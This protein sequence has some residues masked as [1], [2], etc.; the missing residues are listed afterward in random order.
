MFVK[1]LWRYPVKSLSGERLDTALVD[2]DGIYGDRLVH[3]R[4]TSRI[5][6]ARTRYG[7]LGLSSRLRED[8]VPLIDGLPWDDPRSRAAVRVAAGED[9]ELYDDGLVRFDILPL[10]V[11][12][13]GALEAFGRDHRRLRPNIVIGGVEGLAERAWP[14]HALRVGDV[15]IGVDSLR[16]RCVMTTFD[17]DTLEQDVG[18]LREIVDRFDGRIAL[19]CDV[20]APGTIQVGDLVELVELDAVTSRTRSLATP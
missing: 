11:A 9:V 5:V 15:V 19:N 13:D 14:G 1:E 18:V 20:L 6:T 17:P 4:T 3:A 7:L 2:V 12:T 8:G 10:L 16:A